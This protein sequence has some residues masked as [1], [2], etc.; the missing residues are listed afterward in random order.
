M[1]DYKKIIEILDEIDIDDNFLKNTNLGL[2]YNILL[3]KLNK[4][5]KNLIYNEDKYDGIEKAKIVEK[6]IIYLN[7]IKEIVK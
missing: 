2:K 6:T 1:V 7:S 3:Y 5:L 4:L